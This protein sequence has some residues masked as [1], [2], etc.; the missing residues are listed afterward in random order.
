MAGG[1]RIAR[2]LGLGLLVSVMLVSGCSQQRVV[3]AT[4][5]PI[6]EG[7]L[8]EAF[9]SGDVATAREAIPSQ[10]LLIRG[11]CRAD[12]DRV[13]TWTTVTQ[14]YASYALTFIE[15]DDPARAARLYREGM[16]LGLVFLK[17]TAW[18]A[19][20]WQAGPDTL[21]AEIAAR[22]PTELAPIMMW[23]AV[24][25]GK[26]VLGNLDRPREM[27]DLP[28]AHVLTDAVI[29][30]APDYFF[31]MPHA[32]KGIMH[33]S[34]PLGLGGD[35]EAAAEQFRI[36]RE[37][38]GE[39]FVFHDVFFA[40]YYCVTALDEELF[41]ATLERVLATPVD[42]CREVRLINLVAQQRARDLLAERE[43]LF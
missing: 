38:A 11:L 13:E 9:S 21:R 24:C 1:A 37:I 15:A 39:R 40:R 23:S 20:A 4:M 8:A 27:A 19:D 18:L 31:G 42:R 35:L 41:V 25:L 2:G 34:T 29:D 5:V 6:M 16:E 26:H 17:R 3:V 30:L 28:Y 43:D 12:S 32:L 7:A 14:L 22:Q 36:A 10:I 33:A